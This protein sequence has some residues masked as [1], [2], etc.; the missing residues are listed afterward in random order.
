MYLE[1]RLCDSHGS[2]ARSLDLLLRTPGEE[3]GLHDD[4]RRERGRASL[5]EDLVIAGGD[6]VDDRDLAGRLGDL[7]R[8]EMS[9]RPQIS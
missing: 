8:K 6:A 3:L 1:P 7:N 5:A 2:T 4:R 9:T